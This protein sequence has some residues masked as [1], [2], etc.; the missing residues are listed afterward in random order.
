MGKGS[1]RMAT[2]STTAIVTLLSTGPLS[3]RSGNFVFK[4]NTPV[5]VPINARTEGLLAQLQS[6]KTFNVQMPSKK[7]S[8]VKPK[9]VEV[10]EEVEE[11]ESEEVEEDGEES[12]EEAQV[13]TRKALKG[14]KKPE[15][16]KIA[17]KV[18]AEASNS[19]ARSAIIDAILE[20]QG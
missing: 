15:L 2:E 18:G 9:A 19:D 7:A 4:R 17:K 20:V 12:E 1:S 8:K 13:H 6:T 11:E 10:E 3:Y 5:P 16:L 14:L